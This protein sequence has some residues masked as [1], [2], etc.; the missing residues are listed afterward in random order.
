M[1]AALQDIPFLDRR[2]IEERVEVILRQVGLM[3]VPVDPVELAQILQIPVELVGFDDDA[4]SGRLQRGEGGAR[5]DVRKD[6]SPTRRGFTI[7]H[8][9]AHYVLHPVG[10]WSDTETTMYRRDWPADGGSSAADRAEYQANIFAGALLMPEGILREKWNL[11]QSVP[12]LAPSFQVSK[13]ALMRRM[14]DLAIVVPSV[15]GFYHANLAPARTASSK[16]IPV[17]LTDDLGRIPRFPALAIDEHGGIIPLSEQ[18]RSARLSAGI[19]AIDTIGRLES[20]RDSSEDDIPPRLSSDY[21][22]GH[23]SRRRVLGRVAT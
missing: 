9:I 20:V 5:I 8:E 21:D 3:S 4:T 16:R 23:A 22:G 14:R 1:S 18:E 15:E 17:P 13:S 12:I 10:G 6:D 2:Q 11:F 7:A 19:R